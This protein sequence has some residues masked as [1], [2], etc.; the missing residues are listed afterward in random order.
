MTVAKLKSP[1]HYGDG[2]GLWLQVG[3]KGAKSWIFR[4]T[5]RGKS[6]AMGLGSANTFSLAEAREKALACRK[7]CAEGIDPIE[8]RKTQ[9]QDAA[10]EAAQAMTFRECAVAYIDA[11]RAGWRNAK[12]AAQWTTTLE[13]YAYPHFGDRPVAAVDTDLVV[14]AIGPIW[15]RKPETASRV[16]G[17]IESILDW[18]TTRGFRRSE[19][20]A[21][22]RGHLEN[23]LPKRSR[24]QK[25]KHHAALPFA[26]VPSFLKALEFQPGVASHALAFTILT[27]AR[28]GETLG[29]TW[30]EFDLDARIW[31]VPASRMKAGVEHRIP[32][33]E[34]ALMVLRR[35]AEIREG[36]FVFPGGRRERPLS[37]MSMLVLLR[38]MQRGDLT[39]HGF[40]SS[41]RDWAAEHTDFPREVVE[42]ALAHAIESKVERAYRRSDLFAKRRELME[43]WANYCAVFCHE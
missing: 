6:R 29:A 8:A 7:L 4:F 33:T 9:R 17:R 3:D 19:N 22:W 39:V 36:D 12:H 10:L 40:R 26:E 20:P 35:M 25:V 31:N 23:L 37:N 24:V 28:T 16:R 38:R 43:A 1:G 15:A 2:G 13:T 32:L 30:S 27:A 14:R 5:L 41:F 34:S 18:G 42:A 11:H 21:R